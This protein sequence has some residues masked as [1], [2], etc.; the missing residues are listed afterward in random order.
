M[1]HV[2]SRVNGLKIA[3]P[4]DAKNIVHRFAISGG[5]NELVFKPISK[6]QYA[7]SARAEGNQPISFDSISKTQ[8]SVDGV[9]RVELS[10]NVVDD[11]DE[12]AKK[13]PAKKTASKK[14]V[15]RTPP[16]KDEELEL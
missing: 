5:G 3:I 16:K 15:K 7:N 12:P 13:A 6:K 8:T 11:E 4:S 9:D 2:V 10:V 1:A 14:T